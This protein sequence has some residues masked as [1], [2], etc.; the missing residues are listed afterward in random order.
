[1]QSSRLSLLSAGSQ[2]ESPCQSV[3]RAYCQPANPRQPATLLKCLA[4]KRRPFVHILL[5]LSPCDRW[6]SPSSLLCKCH[7]VPWSS[8]VLSRCPR[9]CLS[10]TSD[11]HGT[12]AEPMPR[13]TTAETH[14]R[15]DLQPPQNTSCC[16]PQWGC[17]SP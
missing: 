9:P 12:V 2:H 13:S 5:R 17:C 4:L 11:A 8:G 10:L 14:T 16:I 1:M 15:A 3:F 7:T 6:P